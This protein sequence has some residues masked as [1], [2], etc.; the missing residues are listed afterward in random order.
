MFGR[1][2]TT[3]VFIPV[4]ATS[5]EVTIYTRPRVNLGV[6]VES[7]IDSARVDNEITSA[8]QSRARGTVIRDNKKRSVHQVAAML[9]VVTGA[10]CRREV[11]PLLRDSHSAGTSIQLENFKVW[12]GS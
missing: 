6:R 11:S 10:S 7:P 4:H 3:N 9:L 8:V 2:S 12:I 1:M 5:P